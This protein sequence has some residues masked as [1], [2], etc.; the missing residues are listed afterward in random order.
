MTQAI[1]AASGLLTD[2]IEGLM[3]ILKNYKL[4]IQEHR[5]RAQ[6]IRELS[7]LSNHDLRD[8]G[9]GRS[10][11]RSIAN[12]TFHSDRMEKAEKDVNLRGWN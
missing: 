7:R 3:D 4:R 1:M 5:L 8:L 12:G 2:A 10:D 11:I 9:I 6:T